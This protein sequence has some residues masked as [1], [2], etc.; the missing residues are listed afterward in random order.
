MTRILYLNFLIKKITLLDVDH[1]ALHIY[2]FLGINDDSE[3]NLKERT[4]S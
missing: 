1:P 2:V 3:I 4:S